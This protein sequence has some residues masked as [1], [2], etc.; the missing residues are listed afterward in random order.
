MKESGSP[1]PP[2][3]SGRWPVRSRDI[4]RRGRDSNPR[5]CQQDPVLM[6]EF[7]ASKVPQALS[8]PAIPA[9][10]PSRSR[11]GPT[12]L[13]SC[14]EPRLRFG[15]PAV[16]HESSATEVR[17]A[18]Q[19]LGL[20]VD[21]LAAELPQSAPFRAGN[22]PSRD[23]V[24]GHA[25]SPALARPTCPCPLPPTHPARSFAGPGSYCGTWLG[26]CRSR[27]TWGGASPCAT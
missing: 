18:E 25:Q 11:G 7:D 14:F 12:S 3:S 24:R 9:W 17:I 16:R 22:S 1:R 10:T 21:A 15:E 13:K 26:S 27:A 5:A 6:P 23:A 4:W 2:L 20:G 19:K 8:P